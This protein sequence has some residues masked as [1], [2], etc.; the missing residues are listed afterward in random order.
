MT[1]S[2]DQ[3]VTPY[4]PE[5]ISILRRIKVIPSKPPPGLYVSALGW[6]AASSLFLMALEELGLFDFV[7][8][9]AFDQ[10]ATLGLAINTCGLIVFYLPT[11]AFLLWSCFRTTRL[12]PILLANLVFVIGES[13]T[14]YARL[15]WRALSIIPIWQDFVPEWHRVMFR[16][17]STLIASLLAYCVI[18]LIFHL[19]PQN[20]FTCYR[21]TYDL[22][23]L[24]PESRCPECGHPRQTPP[25]WR[26]LRRID[27]YVRK[28]ALAVAV[29]S[30]VLGMTI[31]SIRWMRTM[32]PI[33]RQLDSLGATAF[34]DVLLNGGPWGLGDGA[35]A[36]G[37][38]PA[39]FAQGLGVWIIIAEDPR[40]L[41]RTVQIQ[42]GGLEHIGLFDFQVSVAPSAC[43]DL[44]PRQATV[45]FRDGVPRKLLD[46][47]GR[48][49]GM[50]RL[51]LDTTHALMR[52]FGVRASELRDDGRLGD[53]IDAAEFFGEP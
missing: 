24:G 41:R 6:G 30:I 52:R 13:M 48:N 9:N 21:C 47:F 25:G 15:A 4:R 22:K 38:I 28:C 49:A 1:P 53:Y 46:R 23:G 8:R 34:S 33:R 12:L 43:C 10:S 27:T 14:D 36:G 26:W 40:D 37:F 3:R 32:A 17:L 2:I 44:S 16:I 5:P 18:R 31:Y 45:L 7:L 29:A 51:P 35:G 39:G 11:M 19:V 20:G 50:A 42:L